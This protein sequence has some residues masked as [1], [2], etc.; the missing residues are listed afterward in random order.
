MLNT[1]IQV[2]PFYILKDANHFNLSD[3][4]LLVI[5]IQYLPRL[6]SVGHA[7]DCQINNFLISQDVD[8]N[9]NRSIFYN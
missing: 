4:Y 2:F 9:K 8:K 1:C 7:F 6:V 5:D 3:Y